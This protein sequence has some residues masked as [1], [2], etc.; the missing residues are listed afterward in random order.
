MT[1]FDEKTLEFPAVR[2]LLASRCVCDLG[3]RR[4]AEMRPMTLPATLTHAIGLVTQMMDLMST[5]QDPPIH[6]LRDVAASLRNAAREGGI[7]EPEELRALHHFLET[8]GRMRSFFEQRPAETPD[9][10]SLAMPLH[11]AP[12]LMRAIDEAIAPENI[13]RDSASP[14]LARL[15]HDIVATEQAIQRDLGRLVRTLA[16]TGDLQDDFFTQR[17]GRYVLP[18][19]STN[20]G[21]V[22]GIIHDSSNSGETVFIEPF[23]ILEHSNKLADLHLSEREEVYRILLRLGAAVRGEL[24]TL[25]ADEQILAEFDLIHAKARFGLANNCAFP[26]ITGPERPL[27]FAEVHHPLLH[28]ESPAESRPLTVA[29]EGTNRVVIITGPNAGGKTTALKTLGLGVIMVQCAVPVPLSPRSH[30]PVFTEVV[31][32]IGDEQSVLEG[33]STF[34]SHMRRMKEM[35]R[36]AGPHSLVLLDELGTATDPGE[37]GALAQAVVESL[38]RC[39]AL[40]IVSTHLAVL[41][42]WAQEHPAGRNASFRLDPQ[43]HRPTFLLQL[44]LPGISEALVVAEQVGIPAEIIERARSL[45]PAAEHDATALILALQ[46]R[47]QRLAGEIAAAEAERRRLEEAVARVEADR[48]EVAEQRRRLRSEALADKEREIAELRARVETLIA[49][50]PSKHELIA[51]QRSLREEAVATRT[52]VARLGTAEP[53]GLDPGALGPGDQVFV[54]SLKEKAVVEKIDNGRG[55]VRVAFRK[56]TATVRMDDLAP[57]APEPAT[58]NAARAAKLSGVS[59]RRPDDVA[60]S[61]DVHGCRVPEALDRIDKFMDTAVAGGLSYVRIVHGHGTGAIRRAL[62]DH[63][64]GHPLVERFRHGAPNEGAGSVTII[65][66]R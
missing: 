59:Y 15:R 32:D 8:A 51:A 29:L 52:E 11:H 57:V 63:L 25:L 5:R 23:A 28:A 16:D 22:P 21:K 7:L 1:S 36:V 27:S 44:D 2:Q 17:S 37:G 53:G 40:T 60:V 13:V 33:E 66:F 46:D 56:M 45:R 49:R 3:R 61:L 20:R 31:A 43:S 24:N 54:R 65:D 10:R 14:E 34:S 41:K 39:G 50:Q 30:M 64:R 55:E 19:K 26:S 42:N 18:V 62:H 48:R 58:D 47:E 9:L 4:V 35:L 6:E 38:A 12:G